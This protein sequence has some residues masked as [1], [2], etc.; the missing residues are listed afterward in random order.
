MR[1]LAGWSLAGGNA[2]S[3]IAADHIL[4]LGNAVTVSIFHEPNSATTPSGMLLRFTVG[5]GSAE[6]TAAW[7]YA[8]SV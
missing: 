7:A 5:I 4:A 8:T 6:K 1:A 2:E 3:S